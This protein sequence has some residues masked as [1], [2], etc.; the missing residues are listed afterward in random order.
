[1]I[2]TAR[3]AGGGHVE[4]R[5]LNR[6]EKREERKLAFFKRVK[7]RILAV[8]FYIPRGT[9][10]QAQALLEDAVAALRKE[11]RQALADFGDINGRFVQDDLY[12]FVFGWDD[13]RMKAHGTMPHLV[14]GDGAKLTDANGRNIILEMKRKLENSERAEIDYSWRNP[15]TR[16]IEPKRSFV[17]RVDGYLVGVGFYP[18]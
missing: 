3:E 15:V 14:G 2:R 9:A 5:W 7:D 1:M 16:Q 6:L 4:Y 10:S 18:R 17:R 11:P 8:G 13:L 12:V